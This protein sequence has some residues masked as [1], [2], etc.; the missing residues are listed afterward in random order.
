MARPR[1]LEEL[2]IHF[3]T[4]RLEWEFCMTAIGCEVC[5]ETNNPKCPGNK[6]RNSRQSDSSQFMPGLTDGCDQEMAA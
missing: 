3:F 1:T 4:G 6:T 5:P 2:E